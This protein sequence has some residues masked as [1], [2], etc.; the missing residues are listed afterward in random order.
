MNGEFVQS[1]SEFSPFFS[2]INGYLFGNQ[3]G[4]TMCKGDKVSWHLLGLGSETDMHGIRF[5]GN[6]IHLSGTTRDTFALFPHKS[7]NALMQADQIGMLQEEKTTFL[8]KFPTHPSIAF[9]PRSFQVHVCKLKHVC[10]N[11]Q[12]GYLGK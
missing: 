3:P 4:L 6:T 9:M 5:Q 1:P 10:G 11:S 2:A 7:T 12:A 8:L